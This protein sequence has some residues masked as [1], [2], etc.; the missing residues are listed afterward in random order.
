MKGKK[1]KHII[2]SSQSVLAAD[3]FLRHLTKPCNS[4]LLHEG[5]VAIPRLHLQLRVHLPLLTPKAC[6]VFHRTC[7]NWLND[8]AAILPKSLDAL[9]KQKEKGTI[10]I[11]I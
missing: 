4:L 7:L 2:H 10:Q 5:T 6:S 3:G 1:T 8:A 11:P 9:P